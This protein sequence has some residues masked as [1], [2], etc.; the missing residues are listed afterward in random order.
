MKNECLLT[1]FQIE[2][3]VEVAFVTDIH[4]S[5]YQTYVNF[6]LNSGLDYT[7]FTIC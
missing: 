7:I 5:Y 4:I 1:L 2:F 6:F 3:Y